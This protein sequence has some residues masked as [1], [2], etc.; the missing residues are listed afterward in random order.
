VTNAL[1]QVTSY[2]YDPIRRVNSVS[3]TGA[4]PLA[5]GR[6]YKFDADGRTATATGSSFGTM[7]YT[8]D[9][10]G[11]E[12]S[13]TEPTTNSKYTG[14]SLICYTNYPDGLREYLSIG[15]PLKDSCSQNI[16]GSPGNGGIR[17]QNIFSY[18]YTEDNR[19]ATQL[20]TWG[21]V[22][23]G[24][25]SYINTFAW[26]YTPS[27]RESTETDPLTS[28]TVSIPNNGSTTLGAKQYVYDPYGR[29]KKLIFPEGYDEDTFGYD[30]DDELASYTLEPGVK[31][32]LTL[33]ARGE[34]LEDTNTGLLGAWA[35]GQTYSANGAQVG[36][37]DI[38]AIGNRV[39]APPTTL[40]YD[41]RSNMAT[42]MPDPQWALNQV[43]SGDTWAF[44]YDNAGRQAYAY[45]DSNAACG[46]N[47]NGAATTTYDAENHISQTNMSWLVNNP[48]NIY[49][50]SST[51][52]WGPDG[53]QRIDAGGLTETAHWDVDSLLFSTSDGA[54]FLYI[55]KNAILDSNNDLEVIDRD[56][57]GTQMTSH[58]QAPNIGLYYTGIT[59]GSV[60]NLYVNGK[61]GKV[62]INTGS[63]SCD[64]T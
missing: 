31:R 14:D 36:D 3:F 56:E 54:P 5:D 16:N 45:Q 63:G 10:D 33:N 8:Y 29:V 21:N 49:G 23:I 62:P 50:G 13:V 41:V 53:R 15:D 44:Q 61:N 26:T 59:T 35:Q 1:N 52:T 9:V 64:V 40:Q 55:G 34:L 24:K 51:V 27:G 12:S 2:A 60:R 28:E 43:S 22:S 32:T 39:Q 11:N 30:Y 6:T 57:R 20:L 58:G 38:T 19:L 47:K 48:P 4:A 46:F 42:C 18:A 7:I 25:G 17:Q 37:G